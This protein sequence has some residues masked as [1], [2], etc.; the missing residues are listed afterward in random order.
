M[1]Q[2]ASE[3]FSY[4]QLGNTGVEQNAC[5]DAVQSA[6]GKNGGFAAKVERASDTNTL[7]KIRQSALCFMVAALNLFFFFE[8]S[9]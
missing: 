4:E 5:R 2:F 6:D 8:N 1:S 9:Q 7:E 3:P